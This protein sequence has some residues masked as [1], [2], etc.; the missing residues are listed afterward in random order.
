META[1][2]F[3]DPL[4]DQVDAYRKEHPELDAALRTFEISDEAYQASLRA[5]TGDRTFVTSNANGGAP[6]HQ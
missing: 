1:T 6:R 4:F 3:E 5:M 2:Q